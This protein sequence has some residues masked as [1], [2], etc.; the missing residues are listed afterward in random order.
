MRPKEETARI[1]G[2]GATARRIAK[3]R[4]TRRGRA[5]MPEEL[6]REAVTLARAHGMM[7]TVRALQLDYGRLKKRVVAAGG[8]Q[9]AAPGLALT[10]SRPAPAFIDVGTAGEIRQRVQRETRAVAGVMAIEL[11]LATGERLTIRVDGGKWQDQ[12]GDV[13]EIRSG[14]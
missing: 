2:F 3:W 5:R 12:T 1:E 11:T 8:P 4:K 6:W 10:R 14:E 13:R 7:P 9:G